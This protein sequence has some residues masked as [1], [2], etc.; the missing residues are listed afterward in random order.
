MS[1]ALSTTGAHLPSHYSYLPLF[2][3]RVP[4][5]LARGA[6][7]LSFLFMVVLISS[8]SFPRHLFFSFLPSY[9]SSLHPDKATGCHDSLDINSDPDPD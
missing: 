9:L 1:Q 8:S 2:L 5:F 4:L 3:H 6:R 7:I